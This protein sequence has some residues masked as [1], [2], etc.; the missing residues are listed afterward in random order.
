MDVRQTHFGSIPLFSSGFPSP[1]SPGCLGEAAMMLRPEARRLGEATGTI[2]CA[3][4]VGGADAVTADRGGVVRT[5][6][7]ALRTRARKKIVVHRDCRILLQSLNRFPRARERCYIVSCI[8]ICVAAPWIF[9][10]IR[11]CV[12]SGAPPGWEKLAMHTFCGG[13]PLTRSSFIRRQN[14]FR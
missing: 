5:K 3:C 6:P 11:D 2:C 12:L 1:L 8:P 14:L 10:H 4:C 9:Y 7:D 13:L